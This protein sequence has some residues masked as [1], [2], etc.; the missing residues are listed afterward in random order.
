MVKN[1]KLIPLTKLLIQRLERLSPDSSWAHQASGIRGDLIRFIEM[2]EL[3]ES[4]QPFREQM[5]VQRL[6][7]LM[8][9][10]FELLEKAARDLRG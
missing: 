5:D 1:D 3:E 7:H 4:G 2:I 8:A 6:R 9:R 10:S